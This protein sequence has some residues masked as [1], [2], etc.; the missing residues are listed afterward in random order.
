MNHMNEDSFQSMCS[1]YPPPACTHDLRRYCTP[2]VSWNVD[3]VL[4]KVKKVKAN[5]HKAFF[6][7]HQRH[8]SLFRPRVAV[9]PPNK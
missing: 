5:L 9:E 8:E 6:A 1:K 4:F 7:G 2:L 3:N